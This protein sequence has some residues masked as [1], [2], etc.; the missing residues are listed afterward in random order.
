[1]RLGFIGLG[2]MGSLMSHRLVSAGHELLVWNRNEDKCIPLIHVGARQT[3]SP[4]ALVRECDIVF[5]CLTDT[6]A[7][8]SVFRRIQSSVTKNTVLVD[9]SSIDPV[10]TQRLSADTELMGSVWLD[11]P[12]SGGVSGAEKGTLAVMVGGCEVSLNRIRPYL[13]LLSS[14]VT[15]MGPSGSGQYAKICNQMIVSCNALVIAEV[16]S[17]AERSGVDSS[18]LAEAFRGGF[19]DSK[20]LQILAPEMSSRQF[21]PVKWHVRT[22]LKDLDMA[23]T[24]SQALSSGAPM[25]GLASQLMRMHAEN[26]FSEKDPSTLI[27]MYQ[28]DDDGR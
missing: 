25:T 15:Y 23:V 27:R 20:P 3:D 11:C 16:V 5:F 7:V 26:G 13:D 18:R 1:M 22:L 24:H 14:Q 28:G 12:V 9:F 10:A 19:A 17:F 4:E 21:E 2:L 6:N 8:E